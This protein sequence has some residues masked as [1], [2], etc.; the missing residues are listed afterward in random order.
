M[1]RKG[2]LSVIALG[3]SPYQPPERQSD[4]VLH[5]IVSTTNAESYVQQYDG[6]GHPT[7]LRS[8]ASAKQFR[9]AKNDILS[10]MGIV[11]S[12]EDG[13][14]RAAKEG[15]QV[16]LLAE[17]N[18]YG[19][20]ISLAD[21]I[22]MFT[23]TWWTF[24]LSTRLQTFTTYDQAPLTH[25]IRLEQRQ[26]GLLGFYSSG[27]PMCICSC[28]VSFF[29]YNF[30]HSYMKSC[31]S[32]ISSWSE[33]RHI[34]LLL[35]S[36][37]VIKFGL[38][39]VL[40]VVA[41]EGTMLS[42]LQSLQLVPTYNMPSLG[43]FLPFGD[44][45]LLRL[46]SIHVTSGQ[47]VWNFITSLVISPFPLIC[48]LSRARALVET[49]IYRFLRRRLPRPDAPDR[50]SF[51]VALEGD[52]VDWTMPSL[53]R[54]AEE[55]ELRSPL[56]ITREFIF[57]AMVLQRWLLSLLSWKAWRQD[58]PNIDG[59]CPQTL[60]HRLPGE[61]ND[62][63]PPSALGT[64]TRNQQ[65]GSSE[66]LSSSHSATEWGEPNRILTGEDQR[67]AQSPVQLQ[68]D[69]TGG[70]FGNDRS[71]TT[72]VLQLLPEPAFHSQQRPQSPTTTLSSRS[73]SAA[74]SSPPSPHVRASLVHQESDMVTMELELLQS[75]QE[76]SVIDPTAAE[77][78]LFG[79]ANARP[80]LSPPF[81][82][83]LEM[84]HAQLPLA[85]R[86]GVPSNAAQINRHDVEIER[87]PL[88]SRQP[89][90]TVT[91][92]DAER[93]DIA[94]HRITTLSTHAADSLAC[95]LA[96]MLTTMLL[97]PIESLALRSLAISYLSPPT[98]T[99]DLHTAAATCSQIRSLTSWFGGGSLSNKFSYIG[100][101]GLILGLRAACHAALWAVQTTAVRT[102]GRRK[103]GWGMLQG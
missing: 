91:I 38:H 39:C 66:N 93:D 70:S 3:R 51:R 8:K 29:R 90:R 21:Q 54:R 40:S 13:R 14:S 42:L 64:A 37:S 41:H 84:D 65:E 95:H 103:F 83:N 73:S 44:Y 45:S 5:E 9:R 2:Y 22:A 53:S 60:H 34:S 59:S 48:L 15:Q 28:I 32:R 49:N 102:L 61:V 26:Q 20:A 99:L 88:A 100:K 4:A 52:L 69:Y 11:V 98:S 35:R 96:R 18:G 56:S 85:N 89:H 80:H 55:E 79:H 6:R 7:N 101:L 81:R 87:A 12:G 62:N 94:N 17:E 47:D 92:S 68:E 10:T 16:T 58:K 33:N 43:L 75:S 72:S 71:V 36:S 67:F 74:I 27:M 23:A 86:E 1:A 31:Y 57:E 63:G 82:E 77:L 25:I 19:M 76:P 46:P 24:A 78:L 30:L 97:F 50:L